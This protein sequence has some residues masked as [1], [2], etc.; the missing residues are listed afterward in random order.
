MEAAARLTDLVTSEWLV[1]HE[2]IP[3][4]TVATRRDGAGVVVSTQ[5]LGQAAK[6]NGIRPYRFPELNAAD[7]FV[8]DLVTSFSYLGC[9][10]ARA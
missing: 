8:R 5:L 2:G 6:P 7:S 9:Q 4:A 3:L 10:V 1:Q